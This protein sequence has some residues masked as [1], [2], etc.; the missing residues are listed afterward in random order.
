MPILAAVK[1][2]A[3]VVLLGVFVDGRELILVVYEL[4]IRHFLHFLELTGF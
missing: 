2:R 1:A 3:L 4:Q